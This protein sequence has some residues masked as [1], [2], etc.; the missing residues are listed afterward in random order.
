MF[1]TD[2]KA[3]TIGYVELRSEVSIRKPLERSLSIRDTDTE[4]VVV[5][6]VDVDVVVDEE[7]AGAVAEVEVDGERTIPTKAIPLQWRRHH[8]TTC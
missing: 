4:E 1:Q 6:A 5:E 7:V 2:N 8:K 3:L